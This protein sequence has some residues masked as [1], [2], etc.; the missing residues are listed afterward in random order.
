MGKLEKDFRAENWDGIDFTDLCDGKVFYYKFHTF[1]IIGDYL[2]IDRLDNRA[3]RSLHDMKESIDKS[4]DDILSTLQSNIYTYLPDTKIDYSF[5]KTND[6]NII[7]HAVTLFECNDKDCYYM[8]HYSLR[9]N[10][11]VTMVGVQD[12]YGYY[13]SFDDFKQSMDKEAYI[14][15][16]RTNFHR[17]L[18]KGDLK[19]IRASVDIEPDVLESKPI[20]PQEM[21]YKAIYGKPIE[22]WDKGT[23]INT[24]KHNCTDLN[25]LIPELEKMKA[26]K[27]QDIALMQVGYNEYAL[28]SPR[29]IYR[30]IY[31][32]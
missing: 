30:G 12:E 32:K 4:L 10:S 21:R 9:H 18:K 11:T 8:L 6:G 13:A 1:D 19:A 31:R 28:K 29:E 15:S 24:I 26:D 3:Y 16:Q 20:M 25:F 17:L 2:L 14:A 23:I 22:N 27:L 7:I 5:D